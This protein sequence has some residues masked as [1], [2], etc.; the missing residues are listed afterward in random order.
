[1]SEKGLAASLFGG[2]LPGGGTG[3]G[4]TQRAHAVSPTRLRD[5]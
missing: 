2:V 5:P 3:P 4:F 1:M